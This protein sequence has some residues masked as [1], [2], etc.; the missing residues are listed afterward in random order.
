MES[1]DSWFVY[2]V[3]KKYDGIPSQKLLEFY[4][5][6]MNLP[7]I[8]PHMVTNMS[9]ILYYL[10]S[11]LSSDSR[12][13]LLINRQQIHQ[14]SKINESIQMYKNTLSAEGPEYPMDLERKLLQEVKTCNAKGAS[15]VINKLLGYITFTEGG[16]LKV[17]SARALELL[18]LMSRAAIEGGARQKNILKYNLYYCNLIQSASLQET[19]FGILGEALSTFT[20][21][22][23]V[24]HGTKNSRL[25]RKAMEYVA[26]NFTSSVTLEQTAEYMHLNPTYLSGLFKQTC[27]MSF[28]NYL[29]TLRIEESR[30]LLEN[31]DY[32]VIN[33]AIAS[34]FSDQSYFSK[35][36]KRMVGIS[37]SSYRSR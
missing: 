12:Q 37:P 9:R 18:F 16:D 30:R 24:Q 26:E 19:I 8:P 33:I 11:G 1:P 29:N 2:E 7:V 17:I 20:E 5:D 13:Q 21:S 22:E 32:S 34:G 36:F 27:G 23:L 10:F 4:E 25:V 6:S 35:V 15:E 14:Q 31:T 3:A 28:S